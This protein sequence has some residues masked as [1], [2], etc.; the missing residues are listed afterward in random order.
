MR[1]SVFDANSV[2]RRAYCFL[3]KVAGLDRL[4]LLITSS[5]LTA[6]TKRYIIRSGIGTE[7]LLDDHQSVFFYS[8]DD[9]CVPLRTDEYVP[10][11]TDE[12]RRSL[13]DRQNWKSRLF[14]GLP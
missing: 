8:T 5:A 10:F 11:R 13:V 12:Q 4:N 14:G 1:M 7:E 3:T 2:G 9:A 6:I